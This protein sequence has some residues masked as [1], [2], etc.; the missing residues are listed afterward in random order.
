MA[1]NQANRSFTSTPYAPMF[2]MGEAPTEPGINARFSNPFQ[3]AS[4]ACM[5]HACHDSPAPTTTSTVWPSSDTFWTPRMFMCSIRPAQSLCIKT[6]EPPPSTI[7][8]N[9]PRSCSAQRTSASVATSAK[10]C[11]AAV[12]P[13]VVNGPTGAASR[14]GDGAGGQG[15]RPG[16]GLAEAT[17]RSASR[18]SHNSAVRVRTGSPDRNSSVTHW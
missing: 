18:R 9:S 3:P 12:A 14:H 4:K 15:V 16:A 17:V 10:H 1:S 5:T 6:L 11:A 2:C 13:N 8:G 7:N